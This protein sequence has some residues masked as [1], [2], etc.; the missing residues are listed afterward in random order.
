MSVK[1]TKGTGAAD[2]N[3]DAGSYHD[4]L[5]RYQREKDRTHQ[6][7][8][9]QQQQQQG[10]DKH[11]RL[12]DSSSSHARIETF[13][14]KSL[15]PP[16]TTRTVGRVS[17]HT[18][19]PARVCVSTGTGVAGTAGTAGTGSTRKRRRTSE[20]LELAGTAHD[21]TMR[22]LQE[23][24][25]DSLKVLDA[26]A[27]SKLKQRGRGRGPGGARAK[28][29]SGLMSL[30]TKAAASV[31]PS[32]RARAGAGAGKFTAT[33]KGS[34]ASANH[35]RTPIASNGHPYTNR[36]KAK[37]GARSGHP[38]KNRPKATVEARTKEGGRFRPKANVRGVMS[39]AKMQLQSQWKGMHAPFEP[40]HSDVSSHNFS[41]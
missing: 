13:C 14:A 28:P 16:T 15:Q 7:Q 20:R 4:A 2:D 40:L 22:G 31:R 6:Q 27:A 8:Q 41:F 30:L 18:H 3:T 17:T 26:A 9:Q 12:S 10:A 24:D 5:A 23:K 34:A 33:G 1:R 38:Y 39:P 35:L 37:A 19:A 11:A 25:R 29:G 36:P 21:S 32:S